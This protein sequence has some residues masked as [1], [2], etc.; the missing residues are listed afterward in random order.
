MLEWP[1]S[2]DWQSRDCESQIMM[3][4]SLLPLAI[5]FPSGLHATDQTLNL[6]EVNTRINRT[7][8]KNSIK[9]YKFECPVRV[10]WQS[11]D[12]E[13]QILMVWSWL[14]LA[15]CFPSGLHATEWTLYLGKVSTQ[16]K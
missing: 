4:S 10:D 8:R 15:I 12:C 6:R 14:P 5:C 13:S 3:V 16:Q 1:V 7:N 11:R 2:V 9:T